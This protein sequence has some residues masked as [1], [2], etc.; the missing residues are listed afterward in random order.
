MVVPG[1]LG[2]WPAAFRSTGGRLDPITG[3]YFNLV[4]GLK[5]IGYIPGVSLF[6]FPYDW[7]LG[8]AELGLNLGQELEAICEGPGRRAEKPAGVRV[9]YSRVDLVG[10]SMGG[11]ICRSYIQGENYRNNVRRLALI[12]T[13]NQGAVAAY[14]GYEG[15][16]TAYIGIPTANARSIVGLLEARAHKNPL[17]RA[18]QTYWAI[19]GKG[20]YNLLSYFSQRTAAIK[21][22]LPLGQ[23]N[24][25]YSGTPGE[26]EKVYSFGPTPGYP[27]NS[28][29]EGL[30]SPQQFAKLD[31]VEEIYCFYSAAYLTRARLQVEDRPKSLQLLYPHGFPVD[32]Q[33]AV[34]F[35]PGDTIVTVESARLELPPL[36]P[37]NSAWKV[38]LVNEAVDAVLGLNLDHVQI[39]G[40]PAPVRHLLNYLAFRTPENPVTPA[41][42]NG[43]PLAQRKP[44]FRPLIF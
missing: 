22:L 12:A 43:L 4:A 11:L 27:V 1:F 37:D 18:R 3:I 40:D 26:L 32:C 28:T 21:D 9:D 20:E 24:Y 15:G 38:K 36:K 25:L 35:T 14:Y 44:N 8:I 19:K 31:R 39:I 7:R 41:V 13:P 30:V 23:T 2:T 34:N 17:R 6:E 33:P 29:L 10:H 42:W 5:A 16:E